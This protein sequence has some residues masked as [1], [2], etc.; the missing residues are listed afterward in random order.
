MILVNEMNI[1]AAVPNSMMIHIE[2]LDSYPPKNLLQIA[3]PT[4][5]PNE[6]AKIVVRL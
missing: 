2:F 4:K 3:P 1:T 6:G 5:L